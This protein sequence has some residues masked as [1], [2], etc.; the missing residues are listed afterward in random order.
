MTGCP[1][2]L[3]IDLRDGHHT[4]AALREYVGRDVEASHYIYHAALPRLPEHELALLEATGRAC[5]L[6]LAIDRKLGEK[7]LDQFTK[8]VKD[9]ADQAAKGLLADN[10]V[11]Y[12]RVFG[13]D[14]AVVKS[15]KPHGVKALLT[16]LRA[17]RKAAGH[18]KG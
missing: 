17:R 9:N 11:D 13:L 1:K 16:S 8:I 12:A 15:I 3:E 10:A 7:A 5:Q 14:G 6:S 4:D 2:K 18:P